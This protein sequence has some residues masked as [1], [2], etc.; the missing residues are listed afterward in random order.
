[1]LDHVLVI[2]LNVGDIYVR[3]IYIPSTDNWLY[4]AMVELQLRNLRYQEMLWSESQCYLSSY[5]T[6]AFLLQN[7]QLHLL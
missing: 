6:L 7:L 3:D 1:M 4:Q 5:M 2:C